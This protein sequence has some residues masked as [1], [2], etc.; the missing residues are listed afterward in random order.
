[1]SEEEPR[2]SVI[3]EETKHET[4]HTITELETQS[5][6]QLVM[7]SS[8]ARRTSNGSVGLDS[9]RISI[10]ED[11]EH[12]D[13]D[14]IKQMSALDETKS[15]NLTNTVRNSG[16]GTSPETSPSGSFSL[17]NEQKGQD[18]DAISL[19]AQEYFPQARWKSL[20][21]RHS[22]VERKTMTFTG[23]QLETMK[24]LRMIPDAQTSGNIP[25]CDLQV[26]DVIFVQGFNAVAFSQTV[27][28]VFSKQTTKYGHS[29]SVHCMIVT[30]T[31]GVNVQVAHVTRDGGTHA[32]IEDPVNPEEF[33]KL[34][35]EPPESTKGFEG[36]V[37][38][39]ESSEEIR[40][41]AAEVASELVE[42]YRIS[43]ATK[44]GIG[45]VFRDPKIGH[46]LSLHHKTI[47]KQKSKKMRRSQSM[48]TTLSRLRKRKSSANQD[49]MKITSTDSSIA[50]NVVEHQTLNSNRSSI[51]EN[52]EVK[53]DVSD[54][55]W[56]KE[57][58]LS[59]LEELNPHRFDTQTEDQKITE[60]SGAPLKLSLFCS[61]FVIKSFQEALAHIDRV[62]VDADIRIMDI[63]GEACS[64]MAFEGF[65]AMN[66]RHSQDWRR[67]GHIHAEFM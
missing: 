36:T 45:S 3:S 12:D 67:I 66:E 44:R 25:V 10:S 50:E 38:R 32:F 53:Q 6:R 9:T 43:Y 37:Y 15:D 29:D 42:S 31:N 33:I 58:R 49:E 62:L 22:A 8:A 2:L 1:M 18:V 26:G 20:Q 27:T 21:L 59:K 56:M 51:A 19:D 11:H 5:S 28:K 24:K 13:E 40:K 48:S 17:R 57:G 14:I 55:N 23:P 52:E 65:L 7:T 41:K 63:R 47:F 34:G 54:A 35:L 4:S 46:Y 30:D 39:L 60:A 64:P 61:E 16:A